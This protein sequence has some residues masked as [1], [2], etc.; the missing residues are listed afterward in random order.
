MWFLSL[1]LPN[2]CNKEEL[3]DECRREKN[4]SDKRAN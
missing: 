2:E 1:N 4:L 3:E